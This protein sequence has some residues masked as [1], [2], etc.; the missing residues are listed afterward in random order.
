MLGGN[1]Q[2]IQ[3]LMNQLQMLQGGQVQQTQAAP[4]TPESL[5]IDRHRIMG[6]PVGPKLTAEPLQTPSSASSVLNLQP[7]GTQDKVVLQEAQAL[8]DAASEL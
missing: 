3:R 2:E 7:S 6:V 1:L 4:V 8:E 5:G